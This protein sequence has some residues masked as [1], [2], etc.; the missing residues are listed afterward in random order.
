MP[1]V[2]II[3]INDTPHYQLSFAHI[4]DMASQ[5]AMAPFEQGLPQSKVRSA[6]KD[7]LLEHVTERAEIRY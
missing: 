3:A 5:A 7:H 1:L 4:P 2:W 6:R